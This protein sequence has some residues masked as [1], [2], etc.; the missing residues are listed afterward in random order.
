MSLEDD[1][2]KA[3]EDNVIL[4]EAKLSQASALLDEAI[5]ISEEHG[6]PFYASVSELGQ[7]YTPASFK[8]LWGKVDDKV[9]EDL[10]VYP[11][12]YDG[13]THSAVC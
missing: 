6:I 9:L 13:W 5:A 4:I 10:D 1:F 2:K 7:Q 8:K 12:E 3:V 11:G